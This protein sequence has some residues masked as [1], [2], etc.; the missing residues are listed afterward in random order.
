MASYDIVGNILIMKFKRDVTKRDKKKIALTFLKSHKNVSTVLEKVDKFSGR[1]RIQKTKYLAGV[2]TKEALYRENG[3]VFR[4]N[5]DSCYFSPRLAS[6]RKEIASLIRKGERVLVMFGGIGPYAIVIA[7]LSKAEH[8]MSVEISRSCNIYALENIKRNKVQANVDIIQGDV[9]RV[10]GKRKKIDEKFD[11][12]IMARP[13]LKDSFLDIAFS[14]IKKSGIIHYYGFYAE[15]EKE[16]LRE[17]IKNEAKKVRRKIKIMGLHKA[18][19]IA[20]KKFR[21]RADFVVV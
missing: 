20:M 13:N 17:L 1:L 19:E 6:E 2:K 16:K 21:Y 9:R 8:V 5:V 4:F 18:G 11:R 7:K 15:E 12:I 10:I 3:C 14:V